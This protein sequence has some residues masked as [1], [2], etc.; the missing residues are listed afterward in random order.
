MKTICLAASIFIVLLIET[1][2]LPNPCIPSCF[3]GTKCFDRTCIPLNQISNSCT[4]DFGCKSTEICYYS[5]CVNRQ[6][7]QRLPSYA[8]FIQ[9]RG[10]VN[11]KMY[12]SQN[13]NLFK[14]IVGN[15][16]L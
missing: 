10:Q 5:T 11:Q 6:T 4:S 2:S 3:P 7:A 9:N 15:A 1:Q 14:P 12:S 13:N 16:Y 8:T